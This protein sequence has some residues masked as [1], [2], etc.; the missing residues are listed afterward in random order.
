MRRVFRDAAAAAGGGGEG[1]RLVQMRDGA[2]HFR[3]VKKNTHRELRYSLEGI[4][5]GFFSVFDVSSVVNVIL[6]F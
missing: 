5:R 3:T 4:F 2:Q 6:C 1:T